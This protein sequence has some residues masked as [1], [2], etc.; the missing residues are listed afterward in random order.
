VLIP[1]GGICQISSYVGAG[2]GVGRYNGEVGYNDYLFLVPLSLSSRPS[3]NF[4]YGMD[5]SKKLQIEAVGHYQNY[6][7]DNIY[8]SIH[9]LQSLEAELNGNSLQ[10][11]A[12]MLYK[13]NNSPSLKV[14]A[15]VYSLWNSFSTNGA[16]VGNREVAFERSLGVSFIASYRLKKYNFHDMLELRY[17]FL[18]NVDDD[19]EGRD[20]GEM[21]DNISEFQLVYTIPNRFIRLKM[22]NTPLPRFNG[23]S[24]GR[25]PTF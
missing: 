19:F 14:G 9:D 13:V 16:W 23:K 6:S 25:C 10:F 21:G 2:A 8:S 17:R 20:L 12:Q 1:L 15:G 7:G 11:G 5:L 22:R 24:R 3:V 18:Y 4:L